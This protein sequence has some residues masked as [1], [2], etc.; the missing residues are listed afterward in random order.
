MGRS[1]MDSLVTK[2]PSTHFHV[3]LERPCAHQYGWQD[4][5]LD[6]TMMKRVTCL[7]RER[8]L[9]FFGYAAFFPVVTRQIGTYQLGIRRARCGGEDDSFRR[10]C[11]N[12]D[13]TWRGGAWDR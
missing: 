11:V 1:D 7:L 3:P 13:V 4:R 2:I 12:Y 8:K 6:R 9:R 10:W 5:V